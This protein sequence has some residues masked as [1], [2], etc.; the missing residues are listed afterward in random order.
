MH[1]LF[2]NY[3]GTQMNYSQKLKQKEFLTLLFIDAKQRMKIKENKKEYK[4]CSLLGV[5]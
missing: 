1:I 3:V 2:N 4:L 5:N